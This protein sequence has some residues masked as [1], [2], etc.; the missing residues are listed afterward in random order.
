MVTV[1]LAIALVLSNLA[2]VPAIWLAYRKMLYVET[3]IL[4][5]VMAAS[6]VF[7]V[8]QVGWFC[9]GVEPHALQIT[10]HFA[11]YTALIWFSLYWVGAA[12]RTRTALT[13]ATMILALPVIIT[14]IGTLVSGA[15][16][17]ALAIV[18]TLSALACI[19][20]ANGG[21]VIN[22]GAFAATV[23]LLG[24]GVVL[25]VVGGDFGGDNWKYPIAHTL[26]HVFAMVA[27][28]FV[29][30]IP[31]PTK[32]DGTNWLTEVNG[33]GK[34]KGKRAVRTATPPP[35]LLPSSSMVTIG[36]SAGTGSRRVATLSVTAVTSPPPRRAKK[37][38]RKEGGGGDGTISL[39]GYVP[40]PDQAVFI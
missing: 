32:T 17:I 23:I 35:S 33:K 12:E 39:A 13:I 11:V 8:C 22:C 26:W 9:F 38:R 31:Y 1:G 2:I 4:L 18:I 21:L 36:A 24:L 27:L 28:F 19:V 20:S 34:G 10:D 14:F 29:V 5:V 6:T 7:H 40:G 37:S 25:H 3:T 15:F 16:V 30:A